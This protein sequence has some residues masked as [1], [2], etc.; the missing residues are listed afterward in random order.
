MSIEGE[1]DA[2]RTFENPLEAWTLFIDLLDSRVRR[3]IGDMLEKQGKNR[4]TGLAEE[5]SVEN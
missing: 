5:R 1:P 3:R 2:G 4:Y